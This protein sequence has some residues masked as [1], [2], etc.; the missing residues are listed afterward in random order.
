MR[1]NTRIVHR[2][3]PNAMLIQSGLAGLCP[4]KK[5][6]RTKSLFFTITRPIDSASQHLPRPSLAFCWIRR[7]YFSLAEQL[8]F[9]GAEKDACG[10]SIKNWPSILRCCLGGVRG[11]GH[12]D[13]SARSLLLW[14]RERERL[15]FAEK[16]TFILVYRGSE[17]FRELS[18]SWH[19]KEFTSLV[20]WVFLQVN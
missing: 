20:F 1:W 6:S 5:S 16:G 17:T 13:F 2:H 7:W 12:I 11:A 3:L 15:G 14:T 4:I 8:R 10:G 19:R 18:Q 9:G